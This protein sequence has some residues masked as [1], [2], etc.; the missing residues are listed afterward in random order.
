MDILKDREI[1]KNK[2]II[3]TSDH[4]DFLGDFAIWD[5]RYFYENVVGVPL[6]ISGPGI[7]AEERFNAARLSKALISNIDLYATIMNLSGMNIDGLRKRPGYNILEMLRE[8]RGVFRNEVFAD[9]ATSVMIRTGNWKLVFDPQQGGVQYFFNLAIDPREENN[10][11]GVRGYESI[12]LE[13]IQKVLS[14]RILKT[15]FTHIKEEQR[16]Q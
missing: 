6:I 10:L 14:Y 5:K 2:V 12:T 13:L 8:K 11:A 1:R 7:P 3:F 4:G 15:Q 9:L 16:I